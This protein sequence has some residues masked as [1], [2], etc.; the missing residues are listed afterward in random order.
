METYI[1]IENAPAWG[2]S[3][4]TAR[5]FTDDEKHHYADWYK[6]IG[7]VGM[8]GHIMLPAL[9]WS[10]MPS[11]KAD[12]AFNGCDNQ[13]WIITEDEK[14]HYIQINA[15]RCAEA[16]RAEIA[17][18]REYYED[19]VRHAS[20]QPRLYTRDE[21]RRLAKQYNDVANEGGE[22]YIPHYYTIDEVE[23]AKQWLSAHQ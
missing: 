15:D 1:V 14:A 16:E 22:G 20:M 17:E 12:G 9:K 10:D 7:F 8:G 2:I 3:I 4:C 23:A 21:A 18:K 6:D 19:V 13:A 11:R 5:R